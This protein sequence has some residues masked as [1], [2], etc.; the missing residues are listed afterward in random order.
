MAKGPKGSRLQLRVIPQFY[1][2]LD[3]ITELIYLLFLGQLRA[4]LNQT[5]LDLGN[6]TVCWYNYTYGIETKVLLYRVH[7]LFDY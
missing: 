2:R 5:V 4:E 1:V 3:L 6:F 7:L